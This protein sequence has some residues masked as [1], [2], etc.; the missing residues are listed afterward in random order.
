[1]LERDTVIIKIILEHTEKIISKIKNINKTDFI[2]NT[3]LQEIICF[4]ILQIGELCNSIT[5]DF[6]N[7][8]DNIPWKMIYGMRNIIVHGYGTIDLDIVYNTSKI[9]IPELDKKLRKLI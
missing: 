9:D 6:K 8:H 1:M 4:N 2:N 3:D 7:A 5:E